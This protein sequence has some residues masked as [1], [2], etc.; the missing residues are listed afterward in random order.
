MSTTRPPFGVIVKPENDTSSSSVDSDY[1][2]LPGSLYDCPAPG[3]YPAEGNCHE[4]YVCQE[5]LPGKLLADTV[6]RCP[7]RYL[8]DERTRR[9]QREHRV[10]CNRFNTDSSVQGKVGADSGDVLVVIERFI[11]DF[12]STPLTYYETRRHFG[13]S[14]K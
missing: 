6:Y 7:R 4:F 9:C 5:V 13:Y 12:F 11:D 2:S 10:S 1:L 14:K 8:F 3:F